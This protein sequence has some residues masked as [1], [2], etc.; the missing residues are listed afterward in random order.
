MT[1]GVDTHFKVRL[2]GFLGFLIL[3]SEFLLFHIKLCKFIGFVNFNIAMHEFMSFQVFNISDAY[4]IIMMI[5]TL[6]YLLGSYERCDDL[7]SR[8]GRET[9]AKMAFSTL[10]CSGDMS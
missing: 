9:G 10:G 6:T 7:R 8:S 5:D 1:R 3:K 4:S 2:L